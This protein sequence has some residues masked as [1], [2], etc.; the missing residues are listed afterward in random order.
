MKVEIDF[1]V[2]VLGHLP[3]PHLQ[4]ENFNESVSHAPYDMDHMIWSMKYLLVGMILFFVPD[5]L[6]LF[7]E[8]SSAVTFE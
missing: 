5:K 3:S 6:V 1:E 2:S 8:N 4:T 7:F